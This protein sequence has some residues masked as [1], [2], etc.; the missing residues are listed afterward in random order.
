MQPHARASLR[1]SCGPTRPGGQNPPL[2]EVWRLCL[3]ARRPDDLP[4]PSFPSA[5]SSPGLAPGQTDCV[6]ELIPRARVYGVRMRG[7]PSGA[8]ASTHPG[9][10]GEPAGAS[11][12]EDPVRSGAPCGPLLSGICLP[13]GKASLGGDAGSGQAPLQACVIVSVSSRCS[14]SPLPR[15]WGFPTDNK[16]GRSS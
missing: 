6:T 1:R 12:A 4:C 13:E 9:C 5:F 7:R 3:V 16:A 2:H 10:G 14:E 15:C 11:G 8:R